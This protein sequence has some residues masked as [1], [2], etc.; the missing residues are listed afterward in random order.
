M[1]LR[2]DYHRCLNC[3]NLWSFNPDVGQFRCPRCRFMEM[4]PSL[5]ANPSAAKLLLDRLKKRK[6]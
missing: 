2:P 5:G 6:S 1:S 3:G 4:G